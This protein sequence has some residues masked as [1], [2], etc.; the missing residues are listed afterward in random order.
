MEIPRLV[1]AA[2][3]SG[4]GKTTIVTAMIAALVARG[5]RVAPFKVGPDYIDPSYHTLAAGR[6]SR[7]LD[8]WMLTPER[9]RATFVHNAAGADLALV[10]G[11][12]GLFDGFSGTDDSGGTA[13]VARILDAPVLL[14]LD[15]GGMARSAAAIVQGMRDFDPRIRLAGV[16]L[17]R[18]GSPAHARMVTEA[19][20]SATA[21]P[22]VGYL[23]RDDEIT[24]PE[25]H[26][27][28]VPTFEPGRW[29]AW[30]DAAATRVAATV[31]LDRVIRLARTAAP[32]APEPDDPF[33]VASRSA[34]VIAVA[35]DA[36]FNFIYADNLDLLRA[37]GAEIAFFSPLADTTLPANSQALYLCGGFPEMFAAELRANAALH[38]AIRCAFRMGLPIYA[39]C[40]GLMY[41]TER[42]VDLQG[43]A[44]SMVGL[45]PGESTMSGRLTLGYRVARGVR[46][47]WL[48]HA[49]ETVRGHE[50]HYSTWRNRPEDLAPAYELLPDAFSSATST[51]GAQIDQLL[52]SYVH[53]HFLALPD[54]AARFVRAAG[55]SPHYGDKE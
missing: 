1:V 19:I 47:N 26:L 25:R 36:A 38:S 21:V 20:E 8:P 9:V 14:V 27:G 45:L 46:T 23:M 53:L 5:L 6:P 7:N 24:L 29:H 55:T 18:A 40:G 22:V 51:E 31:D 13:H 12:M 2:P 54:L 34:A 43:I 42:I 10:E 17:N 33:V 32:L 35:R 48:V 41:L 11:V 50:F 37:A 52:A 4:S 16:V 3:M 44:H 49:G 15:I 28:L 30:L 39:E